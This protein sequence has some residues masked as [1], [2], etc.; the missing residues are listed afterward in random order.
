MSEASEDPQGPQCEG[1]NEARNLRCTETNTK[2]YHLP[3][4]PVHL[5][6]RW[7]CQKH[8]TMIAPS[9]G[10]RLNEETGKLEKVVS[11]KD[12]GIVME[13]VPLVAEVKITRPPLPE[14]G[15]STE[16][17]SPSTKREG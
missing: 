9:G 10:G 3:G 6:K 12:S 1:Y 13:K 16:K 2:L 8:G 7:F 17:P 14:P 5:Q 15:P 4:K 11:W